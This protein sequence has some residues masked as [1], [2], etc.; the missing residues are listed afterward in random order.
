MVFPGQ[1]VQMDPL[2]LSSLLPPE[3]DL[4]RYYRYEGSLTT[5]DCYEGVIWTIFEKP[6]ELSLP[7]VSGRGTARRFCWRRCVPRLPARSVTPRSPHTLSWH[8]PQRAPRCQL[9]NPIKSSPRKWQERGRKGKWRPEGKA[10]NRPPRSSPKLSASSAALP[11]LP[12]AHSQIPR[13]FSHC[14]DSRTE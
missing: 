6:I 9:I 4:G 12:P 5:P 3:E 14:Q 7:Q 11:L 8:Q 13:L 2:P 10:K 1:S